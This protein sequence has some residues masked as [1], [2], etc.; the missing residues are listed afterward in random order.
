MNINEIVNKIVLGVKKDW[1]ALYKIRYAYLELGRYLQKNTDFF[2]SVDKKLGENNLSFSEIAELYNGES[3]ISTSVICKSS[4]LI[5]KMIL[6]RLGIESELVKSVNNVINY[7]VDSQSM[8]INHWFLVAKASGESYFCTLSS[9]LPYIQMGL[10]TKHFGVNIPYYKTLTNG[11]KQQVYEGEEIKHTVI[12]KEKLKEIDIAIGY[13]K[14][15]YM[16][17]DCAQVTKDWYLQY[18]NASL[19]MLR[20]SMR[21]NKLFYELE[22]DKTDFFKD[23]FTFESD[24][25]RKISFYEDLPSSLSREDWSSWLKIICKHVLLKIEEI[26]G[27]DIYPIPS[28]NSQHWNYDSWLLSLCVQIE[29]DVY[30]LLNVEDDVN[31]KDYGINIMDFK[32]N[33][34]SKKIKQGFKFDKSYDYENIIVILDKLNALSNC[35]NSGLKNG[36][37]NSLLNSLSFHFIDKNSFYD[38]NID[39]NGKLSNYYIANKFEEVFKRIFSC[40]EIRTDFNGMS[41][42]EQVVIIKDIINLMFPEV[43]YDNSHMVSGYDERYSPVLNRIQVFPMKSREDGEYSI[44]FSVGD[45]KTSDYYFFYNPKTNEF[46][47]SNILDVYNDYLIVSDRMK[48][49]FS[50]EEL[51][52]IESHRV[53]K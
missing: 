10:E 7:T 26:I 36:N 33:K 52:D 45:D 9:D 21:S 17:N 30:K 50:V 13:V 25:G 51:E 43:T 14:D 12:S 27:Y 8:D 5:L 32:Y 3:V 39:E 44:V 47:V 40:N 4:S 31:V 35:I 15:Y 46:N 11:E 24:T 48:N 2:F 42:S 20:D 1:P 53:K 37:L 29:A 34:W 38:N 16:Y 19:Y 49:R 22:V 6:D 23:I 41:Y 28:L 18:A